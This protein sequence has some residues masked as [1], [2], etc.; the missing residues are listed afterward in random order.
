MLIFILILL[1]IFLAYIIFRLYSIRFF[2]WKINFP[3]PKYR[4]LVEKNVMVAMKD[5]TKLATD[6]Y[7]P[8]SRWKFPVILARTPYNKS[9]STH[10]YKQ[11][12]EL[13][14]S[15]GYVV[16][17]QDVRGKYNSGGEF[18]PYA[19]E[20]LD[21]NDTINW[22]GEASWSNGNVAMVG[23]SYLGSC[24]WLAARYRNPYLRTIIS[25]FTTQ[26]TYS[27]WINQGIPYLKGPLYWQTKFGSNKKENHRASINAIAKTLWRLPFNNLD[28]FA[29][30]QKVPF[31]QD[32]IKHIVPGPFW[33]EISAHH[34]VPDLDM[35]VLIIGGWYDPFIRA[36]IED[37][38]R[39]CQAPS[40]SKNHYSE[41]IIGPWGHNPAHKFKDVSYGKKSEFTSFLF[42]M[43]EWC[44]NW[45]KENKHPT[46]EL[47]KISY[48]IMGK[49]DW[50]KSYQ[51]PPS[52][53]YE[54]YFLTPE[55]PD[56]TKK[57]ILSKTRF[58]TIHKSR[59]IYNPRNPVLFRGNYL[60][61]KENWIEPIEQAEIL[62]RE[63][64]LIYSSEPMQEE[65]TVAGT[66]KLI[67]YVSSQA[68]DTDFYAKI[69]DT[70]P[71]GRT[72][73]LAVGSV[74]MRY[75]NTLDKPE[76]M[77]P[78]EIYPL[79]ITLKSLAHSFLKYHRIQLQIT[80]SD[81]PVHNRNLN[82]GLSCEKSMDIKEVEQTLYTGGPY[83]SHLLLPILS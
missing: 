29:I 54:K 23:I 48:F 19:Y 18:Y 28:T 81:F 2:A 60:L 30:H 21:G 25:M 45:L 47:K 8:Q 76:L 50:C 75:R 73:N 13:F 4:V 17:I 20:A 35:P 67:L 14:A 61:D 22:A 7:R 68:V 49:N 53:N 79:E 31:F 5:G 74:R 33:D 77:K 34:V 42:K 57:G 65:L 6:I 56:N 58:E 9:G 63:D 10:P 70:H 51:W 64:I 27:V 16:I 83:D 59:F 66:I 40:S 39:M 32:Y 38:Q 26:D 36:T 80:S 69:S 37:Y 11:F 15:Q 55:H 43:L 24:A 41:L 3:K 1:L 46:R 78:G 82:T 71:D 72:Y 52:Q 44:D 12:A 62:G